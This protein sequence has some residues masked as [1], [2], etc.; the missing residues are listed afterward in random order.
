MFRRNAFPRS[1]T[2]LANAPYDCL[3]QPVNAF[4]LR[5]IHHVKTVFGLV[6]GT[7]SRANREL[8]AEIILD[9]R[10]LVAFSFGI[11][12]VNAKG[13]EIAWVALRAARCCE[14]ILRLIAGRIRSA[15]QLK[16]GN[17]TD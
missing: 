17:R 10:S 9:K 7:L 14:K 1:L 5:P 4:F 8:S 12:G 6:F 2:R 11:P 3:H 15:V 13:R 16:P